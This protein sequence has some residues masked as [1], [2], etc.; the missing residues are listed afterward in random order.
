MEDEEGL[1]SGRSNWAG[2]RVVGLVETEATDDARGIERRVTGGVE[3]GS[4]AVGMLKV[5]WGVT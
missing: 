2:L 3:N 5:R 1:V 4:V